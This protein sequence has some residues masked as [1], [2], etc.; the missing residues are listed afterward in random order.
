VIV[1]QEQPLELVAHCCIA[2]L[3]TIL[4]LIDRRRPRK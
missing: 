1:D 2:A 4:W 3:V